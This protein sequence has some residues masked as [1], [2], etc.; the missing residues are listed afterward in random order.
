MPEKTA[1]PAQ[2][3]VRLHNDQCLFPAA[4]RAKPSHL[5]ARKTMN[6]PSRPVSGLGF[7]NASLARGLDLHAGD[8]D[9]ALKHDELLTKQGILH[10]EP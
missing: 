9:L 4:Q 2:H 1:M 3:G 8:V 5:L 6:V 7:A 10:H